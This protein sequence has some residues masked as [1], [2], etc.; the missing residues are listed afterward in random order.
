SDAPSPARAA[1]WP[2]A[3]LLDPHVEEA[4]RAVASPAC[5]EERRPW[6]D[7]SPQSPRATA[8]RTVADGRARCA[9]PARDRIAGRTAGL[10]ARDTTAS[11]RL[12]MTCGPFRQ[13]GCRIGLR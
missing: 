10:R 6:P 4:A 11:V 13:I 8:G 7:A 3:G 5:A 2:V 12:A 1:P 9:W